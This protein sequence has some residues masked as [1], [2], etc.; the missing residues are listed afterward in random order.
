F[1]AIGEYLRAR[2]TRHRSCRN[3]QGWDD[4]T[5][6]KTAHQLEAEGAV[7]YVLSSSALQRVQAALRDYL[8]I[9]ELDGIE[10]DSS[11]FYQHK[12]RKE[13]TKDIFDALD[14][15]L[16]EVGALDDAR[17]Y[18]GSGP[19]SLQGARLV[20]NGYDPTFRSGLFAETGVPDPVTRYFHID[21]APRYAEIKFLLY[22]S[23]VNDDEDGPN[24]YVSGSHRCHEGFLGQL[25]RRAV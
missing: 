13:S 3:N 11:N 19:L 6:G 18:L 1:A 9:D 23:G 10:L 12:F 17:H 15:A 16:R 4:Y 7:V 24:C 8:G 5:P 25:T 22:L 20:I 14:A 2:R 21:S